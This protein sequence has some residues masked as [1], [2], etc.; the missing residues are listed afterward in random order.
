MYCKGFWYNIGEIYTFSGNLSLWCVALSSA[1]YFYSSI[2]VSGITP[3]AG[4][5]E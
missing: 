1:P 3:Q 4:Y 2:G 5:M